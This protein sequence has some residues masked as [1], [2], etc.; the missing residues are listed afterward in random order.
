MAGKSMEL[1]LGTGQ[2]GDDR[3]GVIAT[4]TTSSWIHRWAYYVKHDVFHK[5]LH[6]DHLQIQ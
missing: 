4:L 1:E 2:K 5:I 3:G 6:Y